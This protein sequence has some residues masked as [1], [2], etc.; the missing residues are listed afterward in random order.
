MLPGVGAGSSLVL[1]GRRQLKD[2]VGGS[3][4]KSGNTLSFKKEIDK[5]HLHPKT[6]V[7]FQEGNILENKGAGH[8][9]GC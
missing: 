6:A 3:V 4:F 5:T 8:L 9:R 7:T 2:G 1:D